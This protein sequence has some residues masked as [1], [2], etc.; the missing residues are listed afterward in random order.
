MTDALQCATNK[1]QSVLDCF[2]GTGSTGVACVNLGRKFFDIACR[3]IEQA[4]AQPR[5]FEDAKTI[6]PEQADLC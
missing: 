4:Y 3:R 5:L 6:A 2:M 1:G